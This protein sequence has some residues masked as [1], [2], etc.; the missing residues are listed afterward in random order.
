MFTDRSCEYGLS[1]YRPNE[2]C[3]TQPGSKSRNGVC[4]CKGGS[5]KDQY[6]MCVG[7]GSADPEGKSEHLKF[8]SGVQQ[9]TETQ[10][11]KNRSN[12]TGCINH[13]EQLSRQ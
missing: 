8:C 11:A 3:V 7:G 13:Q 2:E 5:A 6:G 1:Q 10:S 4:T 9:N 12:L